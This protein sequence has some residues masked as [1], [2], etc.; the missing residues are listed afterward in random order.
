LKASHRLGLRDCRILRNDTALDAGRET[1]DEASRVAKLTDK[2]LRKLQRKILRE[3]QRLA[4]RIARQRGRVKIEQAK[5]GVVE[6]TFPVNFERLEGQRGRVRFEKEQLKDL[7]ARLKESNEA[8]G[9]DPPTLEWLRE[10][11]SK[12]PEDWDTL[13]AALGNAAASLVHD[14]P[15]AK[16]LNDVAV[17]T[18]QSY[19]DLLAEK[20]GISIAI[21][22]RLMG[23]DPF[24]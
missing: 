4:Q 21:V 19:V 7:K 18:G 20:T 16:N 11:F 12:S 13:T 17:A 9:E 23:K 3:R 2:D 10:L 15:G 1:V 5:L 6:E 14:T 24:D 22:A 8:Y